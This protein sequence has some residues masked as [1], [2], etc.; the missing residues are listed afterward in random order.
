MDYPVVT[1]KQLSAHLRSL[2]K[3][4]GLTQAQLGAKLGLNQTR[5][6]KIERN[7]ETVS[8]AQLLAILSLLGARLVLST[9]A[10]VG[11]RLPANNS[12]DW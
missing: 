1:P 10:T 8:V 2:R 5:I 12:P 11:P 9:D 3:A 4:H 7:P 6:G